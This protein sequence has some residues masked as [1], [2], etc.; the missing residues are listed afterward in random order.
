[1]DR[2]TIGGNLWVISTDESGRE[3]RDR[4]KNHLYKDDVVF[5]SKL[6]KWWSYA[7]TAK[8]NWIHRHQNEKMK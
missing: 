5:V 1:M 8:M 7:D 6:D 4:L 3:L 2:V